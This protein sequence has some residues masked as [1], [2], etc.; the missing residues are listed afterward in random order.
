M[1][2]GVRPVARHRCVRILTTVLFCVG[3]G[4]A[5]SAQAAGNAP[6]SGSAADLTS[7]YR[8]PIAIGAEYHSITPFGD[9]V[10]DFTV[11]EAAA[12]ARFSLPESPALQPLI[13]AGYVDF[14]SIDEEFPD[15]WDHFH[16]AAGG[17]AALASRLSRTFELAGEASASYS[18]TWYQ[19]VVDVPVGYPAILG[20]AGL[21]ISLIPSFNFSVDVA[22]QVRYL[23]G[24]GDV[25]RFDG[26]AVS[27]GIGA[28]FRTGTDP[29]APQADIR[30]LRF[31]EAEVP[32]AFAALQS[33][34]VS[35][36]LGTVSF[37]NAD[38][39]TVRDVSVLFFQPGF[40][41]SP[42]PAAQIDQL[43]PGEA[44]T[45]DLPASFNA[46]VFETEG[47]TPLTGEIIVQYTRNGRAAEQRRSVT[48][49]LH[50]K[51]ALT[52]TDDR[53]MG[54]FITPADS[55]VRNYA[56]YVRQQNRDEILDG[57]SEPLQV[58]MLAY[59]ALEELGI[60]YQLDP[61]S[62]FVEVQGD[63]NAVDSI[64]LPR[65]TLTRLTGDCDDLTA[66]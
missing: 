13:R 24:L 54:A 20:A 32:D 31:L 34:Y 49:D 37:E 52:W 14:N 61:A 58:A 53:K 10:A 23:Y 30:S 29:D 35:N 43:D 42:T 56:S 16:I 12:T 17:G 60:A 22:S 51:T 21:R 41:D 6:G 7:Y 39:S 36:P 15:K 45:V 44:I 9:Y 27:V 40:M 38:R 3:V 5:V 33:W 65:D 46:D 28:T 62:P 4:A 47:I 57:V 66:L 64:S 55:A 18:Q 59:H 48:Y 11:F 2:K 63:T 50:D 25:D 19:S 8:S 26:F 1:L